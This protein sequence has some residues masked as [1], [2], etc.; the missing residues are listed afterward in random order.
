MMNEIK[1][2]TTT[3]A[4]GPVVDEHIVRFDDI[5]EIELLSNN[6]SVGRYVVNFTAGNKNDCWTVGG[7]GS[8]VK[9]DDV[10]YKGEEIEKLRNLLEQKKIKAM[11]ERM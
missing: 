10:M 2:V 7:P 8:Y 3:R 11:L 5:L 1:Y 9:Y 6:P 4:D